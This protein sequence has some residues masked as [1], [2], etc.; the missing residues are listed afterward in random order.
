MFQAVNYNKKQKVINL[1]GINSPSQSY[2]DLN[3]ADL[4]GSYLLAN[5]R[6]GLANDQCFFLK[7][8]MEMARENGE[9]FHK[10][11]G[12]CI[13]LCEMEPR[14]AAAVLGYVCHVA[15]ICNNFHPVLFLRACCQIC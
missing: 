6:K 12:K 2:F 9:A 11:F 8:K 7:E 5:I 15:S 14:V 1:A 10:L 13:Q 3:N 4:I